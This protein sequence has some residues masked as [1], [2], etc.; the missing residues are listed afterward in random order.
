MHDDLVRTCQANEKSLS[1]VILQIQE[2]LLQALR[3]LNQAR[4]LTDQIRNLPN[5]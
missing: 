3:A 1:D 4:A 5:A 2:T